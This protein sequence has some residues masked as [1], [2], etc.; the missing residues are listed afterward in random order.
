MPHKLQIRH[1]QGQERL[2]VQPDSVLGDFIELLSQKCGI[3]PSR[4]QISFGFPKPSA[5]VGASPDDLTTSLI[6]KGECVTVCESQ[7]PT[8]LLP[9][10]ARPPEAAPQALARPAPPGFAPA[11]TNS[12]RAVRRVV[13]ADNSCLFTSVGYVLNRD[14]V[15]GTALRGVVAAEI[16]ARPEEF[17]EVVLE[18]EPHK[19]TQWI[20]NPEKWGGA[21]ELNCLSEH[22]S[23]V[24]VAWNIQTL[25]PDRYGE[26]KGYHQCAHL[27]YDGLHYDALALNPLEGDDAPPEEFDLTLFNPA[28][29]YMEKVCEELVGKMQMQKQFTDIANF[30]LRCLVCQ[31]GL[32]GQKEAREHAQATGHQNFSEY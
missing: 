16:L 17:P 19:Y 32:V 15:S 6:P 28:D 4:L 22:F 26:G 21:I 29:L 31:Q 11:L 5:L 23:T 25:R 7:E 8:L 14:R 2:E 13:D 9:Q 1:P 20:Q 12:G 27:V 10:D 3:S 24:I 30:T 18:M